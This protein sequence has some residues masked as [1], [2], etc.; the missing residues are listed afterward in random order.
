MTQSRVYPQKSPPDSRI[1]DPVVGE[2]V[3]P[4][5]YWKRRPATRELLDITTH[6]DLPYTRKVAV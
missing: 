2:W 5:D 4:D 1:Y 6:E 3:H